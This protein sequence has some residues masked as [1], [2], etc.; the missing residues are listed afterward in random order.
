VIALSLP[1]LL[2]LAGLHPNFESKPINL[3]GKHA[4]IIATN[5]SVLNAP[6]ETDGKPTGVFLSELSVPYYDFVK[7]GIKVEIA[8]INGGDI[9]IEPMPYFIKT[10]EDKKLL[11]DKYAMDK[12]QNSKSISEIDF[13][14]FDIIFL[15]GGWGAA[16]DLGFSDLLGMKIS[17]AY[18]SSEAII[19]GVCH[20]V[21][22]LIRAKDK[23][24]NL[25]ITGRNM[26]GVTDKQ[27]QE[28]GITMTPQHP[29]TELRKA[30]VIFKS[31]TRF[32]DMFA[33]LTIV[34]DEKR[35]VTGQNQN[36][37]H[38]TAYKMM[39]IVANQ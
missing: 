14:E 31:N 21:L 22:G 28:L 29:E 36:A 1:T 34:D 11:K 37:G 35:F 6:G 8:S 20:G 33:N 18:Y 7:S 39:E 5:H 30:G 19:G 4:L 15:S 16:Y 13:T 25:L 12:V 17:E 24:G 32:R 3:E 27:V 10:K 38:E 9:P 23:D 2:Q 26:T